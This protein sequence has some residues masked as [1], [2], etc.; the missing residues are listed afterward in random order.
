MNG[1]L[2][3]IEGF[4]LVHFEVV[5]GRLWSFYYHLTTVGLVK[6]SP[7]EPLG[8]KQ[9]ESAANLSAGFYY[10]STPTPP[11]KP[12]FMGHSEGGEIKE[13]ERW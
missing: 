6:A 8:G 13:T 9:E 3:E 7:R 1:C 10:H 12:L 4:R 2:E 11:W 5:R